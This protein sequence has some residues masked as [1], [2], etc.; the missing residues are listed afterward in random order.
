MVKAE[1]EGRL[2]EYLQVQKNNREWQ[3]KILS[4]G[5]EIPIA[6]AEETITHSI[7]RARLVYAIRGGAVPR[8]STDAQTDGDTFL[9]QVEGQEPTETASES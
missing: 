8:L 5:L 9:E 4:L 2:K 7:V 3:N 6:E 1:E